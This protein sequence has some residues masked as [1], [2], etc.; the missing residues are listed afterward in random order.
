[1]SVCKSFNLLLNMLP[2]NLPSTNPDPNHLYDASPDHPALT[3]SI[4]FSTSRHGASL[5]LCCH[6]EPIFEDIL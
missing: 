5:S 2:H 3:H 1:M 4:S 6:T